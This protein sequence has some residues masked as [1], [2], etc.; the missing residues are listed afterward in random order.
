MTTSKGVNLLKT[1][2]YSQWGF[3]DAQVI[4]LFISIREQIDTNIQ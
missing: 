1:L 4:L 2:S 3:V